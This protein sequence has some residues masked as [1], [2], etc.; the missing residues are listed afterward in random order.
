MASSACQHA[1]VLIALA[2]CWNAGMPGMPECWNAWNARVPGMLECWNA[3]MPE[4]W[5]AGML[6]CHRMLYNNAGGQ[7]MFFFVQVHSI[8]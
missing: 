4:C 5:N 7:P 2:G 1:Q 6:E 8:I 3:G